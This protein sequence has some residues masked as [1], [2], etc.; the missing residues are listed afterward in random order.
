MWLA[1]VVGLPLLGTGAK[2]IRVP[3]P[4]AQQIAAWLSAN[5][6]DDTVIETYEPELGVLSDHR[7]HYPPPSL[8]IHAVAHVARGAPAPASRYNFR[9]AATADYVVVGPFARYVGLY[10]DD[11]LDADFSRVHEQGPYA[12][13][14][15]AAR[16]DT[17][18]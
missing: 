9:E 14:K 7:Y 2:L 17:R 12:V 13:W 4:D 15:R 16:A 5:L 8:L 11:D 1:V 6:P 18:R 10:G 3:P